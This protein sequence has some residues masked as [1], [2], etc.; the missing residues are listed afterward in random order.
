M[1]LTAV[2]V[3]LTIIAS[4]GRFFKGPE[5]REKNRQP[6]PG[7][8][9]LYRIHWASRI[10]TNECS[11]QS[12]VPYHLAIAQWKKAIKKRWVMGLEPTVSRTTIWR[13]SQLRHTHHK[14]DLIGSMPEGTR[15]PDTRLRRPVLYQAELRTHNRAAKCACNQ[16]SL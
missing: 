5:E 7:Y 4:S 11:S 6:Y 13:V 8:R 9:C 15:T 1:L 10:R 3:S 12:A 2:P 16:L 14:T